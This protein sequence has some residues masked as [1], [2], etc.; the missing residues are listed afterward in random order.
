[1][2]GNP[3][4]GRKL[5]DDAPPPTKAAP[6]GRKELTKKEMKSEVKVTI[7]P[8]VE[9]YSLCEEGSSVTQHFAI[10]LFA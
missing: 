8:S 7:F 3:S 2:G 5:G 10:E 6:A 4:K 9:R 1:M